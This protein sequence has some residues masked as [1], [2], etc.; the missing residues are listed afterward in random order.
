[1]LPS[2]R[3]HVQALQVTYFP[4]IHQHFCEDISGRV[5]CKIKVYLH[6]KLLFLALDRGEY[7]MLFFNGCPIRDTL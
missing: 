7:G 1:M 2:L 3:R 4:V 6:P 5:K